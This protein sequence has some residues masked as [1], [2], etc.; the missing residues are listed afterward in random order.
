MSKRQGKKYKYLL[1]ASSLYPLLLSGEAFDLEQCAVST[2]TEYELGNVLWKETK[3]KRIDFKLAAQT[4]SDALSEL[5]KI[6][7]GSMDDILAMA[8]ERNLTFYDAA[9]AYLAEREDIKLVTEDVDLIKKCKCAIHLKE[10][11]PT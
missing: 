8:L 11:E 4:F 2:L 5:R 6:S 10:M 3:R 9:Y 1:D 7:I